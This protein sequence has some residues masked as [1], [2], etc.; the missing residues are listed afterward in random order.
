MPTT[1]QFWQYAKEAVLSA[2]VAK[3]DEDRECLLELARNWTQ[4]ALT[5][6]QR[7]PSGVLPPPNA[8]GSHHVY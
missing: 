2:A 7:T 3:T 4:A 6:R 1:D 5:E 8:R